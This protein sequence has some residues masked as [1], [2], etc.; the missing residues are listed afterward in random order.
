MYL[1]LEMCL[2]TD[3]CVCYI[4]PVVLLNFHVKTKVLVIANFLNE[5]VCIFENLL[6]LSFNQ[7][8]LL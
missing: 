8:Y 4:L 7:I 6:N 2:E 3:G 1:L 5:T